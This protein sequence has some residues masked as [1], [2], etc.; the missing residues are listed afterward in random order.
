MRYVN[1]MIKTLDP[2]GV[3]WRFVLIS[4]IYINDTG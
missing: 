1:Q 4:K 3:E 2:N